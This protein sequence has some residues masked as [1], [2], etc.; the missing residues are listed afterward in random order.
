MRRVEESRLKSHSEGHIVLLAPL[1]GPVV[2]LAKVPDPVFSGGMFG[3]GIG[4]DPLEGRLVAP[5]DGTI[6][7]LARTGHAVTLATSEGAEILLHIGIDTVELNGKGFAPMVEQGAQVHAGDVLIEFD[8][9][10]VAL[11]APS[12]VSV[13]AIANSDAFEIVE[14]V[15]GGIVKA[16]ET[17]LLVLRAR[18]GEAADA[19]RQLSATNVMEEARRQVTLIHAGGLHARPAARAREAARG[20][21]ARVE[22]R[23]EGRKAAI[24]SV[25]GLLGLGAGEGATVELLGVGSQAQAAIDAI[26]HELTREAQGEVEQQKPARQTSSLAT[27][28]AASP[29]GEPLAPNTLAGVCASPGIAV[30]K[31]VRWDDADVDP[32]EQA[33]GTS[34]AESRLLDK[35]IA[36]VDADLDTVVRDASQ[37]GAVGEAGIF[38]VHRVLLEDPTL[39]DAA[40]DLI[41]LGKSAGFAWREAIRA[42]I[43]ILSK[44]EDA[45]LAERAADLRDI[46]KRV[47][48]AL[49]YTNASARALPDEA[50]LAAEEFTPSDLS[51]LDRS[52]VTALVMSRGGAT[53][54][55][56]IL[57]RQAGIP[58]L[59]AVGDALNAIPAGTQVVV[60]A[61][62]GRLEFAPTD[63]DVERA[64]VERG[65]LADVREANRRTSQQAAVTSD[66]RAIEVAANIATLEDAKTAVDNGADA[67]GLLRTELLFIHRASAPTVDEHRESYQGIVE[68]LNGRTAIIRTL[69]V[70]ADK[71]VDYLTLPPEPN[72]ALGLRGIRLA[73]V[74]PDLLDDQLR[75]LLAVQPL[76]AVRILL[77]MVTD[78]GEL[79]RIRKRI[80]ELARELGR[81]QP[82][83][84][85]VM[86]EVPSA[87]LLADQLAQH[88]DF[89]SI[90]TNDLTQYTLAMDRCQADLAAQADGLHPAVLRL[91]AATVQGAD[92]HGK[93][94]GVCGALA[95]DP[96][97]MPLLVGL[98]VTELSVDPVSVPGAKARVRNLDYQLCRQRA[99][100][101]LALE[102]AQAVRAASRET[103]PLD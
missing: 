51:T 75:G 72:P 27:Q 2:P 43:G 103:W 58:A 20:F 26:A 101:A 15:E 46:D 22:V 30:G 37:R 100:D 6:T 84:V 14:R 67:V 86:I 79:I 3:D 60:N 49:G 98:G 12:L 13:I 45:L 50:V 59:V 66:G 97:A 83:E 17:P 44:V 55:A 78:V 68:A 63:V 1:T 70:G 33:S 40:R 89:L 61:T 99:Q 19:S 56:A 73:Q 94:V 95:G 18:A 34:A 91:I 82:I 76:G 35:A 29:A 47:L 8:Q 87:A 42:Q 32:P 88:A 77:P 80:D 11:N 21:D 38:A 62:T 31:L 28:A 93:W 69:D 102:S 85:G 64:R 71:E 23:Y 4:I 57:A 52:R 65:R 16:G 81:T 41:S 7:H 10:Q 5:C 24:E 48:R 92:K 90:G 9:D 39:L 36:T 54:H 96:L 74:R 25:V 53:S